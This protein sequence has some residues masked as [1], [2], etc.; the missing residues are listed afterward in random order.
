MRIYVYL[1]SASVNSGLEIYAKQYVAELRNA[2]HEVTLSH[3]LPANGW[4]EFDEAVIQ[5]CNDASVLEQFPPEKTTFFVHDHESI[6]PRG[7]AY[8][9]CKC[10]CT[11]PGGLWPC[12]FCAPLCRNAFSALKRVLSQG[13]RKR[14]M[15][16]FH[17]LVVLSQFMKSRLLANGFAAERI[18]VRPPKVLPFG[19]GALES[20]EP[21]P[22][23]L[24]LLYAGQL[25]RGKGVH[26][27]LEAMARMEQKR[28]LDIIGSGNM[29]PQLREM[30]AHLGLAERVRFHGF[31]QNTRKWMAAAKCV[32][33]PSIWQEPYGLVAAEAVSLGKPVVAFA[34]GGLPEACQG[35]ALLVPTGDIAALADALDGKIHDTPVRVFV[36]IDALGWKQVQKYNF[37]PELLPHRRSIEMQ[38]G[39]SCT[40]IPTILTGERPNVHGHLTFYEWAPEQSPFQK[41]KFLAPFLRPASFWRRG[42]V[43]NV[44]SRIVRWFYGFTGYFQLYAVPL[45]RLP[46]LDY[47]EK[48]DLFVRGG[49]APVKNLADVWSEQGLRYHISDWR[50]PEEQNLQIAATLLAKGTLDRA[51]VYAAGFDS[52]QHDH[53]GQD[54]VLQK[55]LQLY[56]TAIQNI[57][58]ALQQAG[59]PFEL[60][61]FS[62]HGMTPL[63][64]TADVPAALDSTG[65]QWGRDFAS[66]VDSTMA[67]F[68]WL[69]DGAQEKVREAF[70][71]HKIPGH[72]LT[73]EEIQYH[74][75]A[76]TDRKFGDAIFLAPPGIQFAPCDMGIKPLHGM[77]GFDPADEDSLACCLSTKPLPPSITRVCDYFTLMK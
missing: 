55:R 27:L 52:L 25:I 46:K 12:L 75:L 17:R 44:L 22:E 13:R 38:F 50:M 10:N 69:K 62:D 43:R 45:E 8:T 14:A 60:T 26:F 6:C 37:L 19:N 59:R 18:E 32:V 73:P 29:E 57:Y 61:V 68:W 49:L 20:D 3:E 28:R 56:A 66:A 5:K 24:D 65:L 64:G 11:R 31:Q 54:D 42:R 4:E 34:S 36:F 41:M 30:A 21:I 72:W 48:K 67:R 70:S 33:V 47:C 74:G 23:D 58:R 53:V 51:F 76:R 63:R 16:R 35:K 2:G 15:A 9:P 71:Q 1:E 77:H 7:Y 39:Y 40:A